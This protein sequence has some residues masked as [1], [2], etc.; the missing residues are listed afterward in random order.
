[1]LVRTPCRGISYLD[2]LL[3]VVSSMQVY[4]NVDTKNMY[5]EL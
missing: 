3:L 5:K 2:S 1:M 4:A